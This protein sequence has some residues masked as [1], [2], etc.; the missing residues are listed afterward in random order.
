MKPTK[1]DYRR[2]FGVAI[3]DEGIV[4]ITPSLETARSAAIERKGLL[5]RIVAQDSFVPLEDYESPK[6]L[7]KC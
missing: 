1:L 4:L 2:Q 5:V 7:K 3:A 6:G